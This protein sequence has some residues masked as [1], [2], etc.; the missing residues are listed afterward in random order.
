[1]EVTDLADVVPDHEAGERPDVP[2]LL[3]GAAGGGGVHQVHEARQ[4]PLG[5]V[6]EQ[7]SGPLGTRSGTVVTGWSSQ[8]TLPDM[9]AAGRSVSGGLGG[10]DR[11]DGALD[12]DVRGLA[13]RLDGL[14]HPLDEGAQVGGPGLDERLTVGGASSMI[15]TARPSESRQGHTWTSPSPDGS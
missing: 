15:T 2:E 10:E 4:G 12:V 6:A 9:L 1:M 8:P 11:G 7:H 5:V 13:A 3:L 14:A